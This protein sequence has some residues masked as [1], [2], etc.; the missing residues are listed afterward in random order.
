MPPVFQPDIWPWEWLWFA[1]L[2]IVGVT[3]ASLVVRAV[4]RRGL[5]GRPPWLR[6]LVLLLAL[7]FVVLPFVVYDD[8]LDQLQRPQSVTET[9]P[10]ATH[11]DLRTRVFPLPPAFVFEQAVRVVESMPSWRLTRKDPEAG[12]ISAEVSV[13]LG[14][15][16]NDIL[17]HVGGVSADGA[18]VD[19]RA[20]ARRPEGDLG[21]TEREIISFYRQ[22]DQAIINPSQ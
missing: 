11:P 20:S 22:L 10:E 14:L 21:T 19:V 15:Y 4:R 18:Q 8:W 3:L 5:G 9:T 1:A 6:Y 16:T 12:L 7:P 17:I 13:A 2:A